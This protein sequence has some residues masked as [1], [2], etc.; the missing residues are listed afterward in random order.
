MSSMLRGTGQGPD[1]RNMA[2]KNMLK[3]HLRP[4]GTARHV[5]SD[6]GELTAPADRAED[7][8]PLVLSA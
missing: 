3:L 8:R 7:W 2:A 4:Y 5:R 1:H 6:P